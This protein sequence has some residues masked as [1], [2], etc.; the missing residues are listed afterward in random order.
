MLAAANLKPHE[1]EVF[2]GP[3]TGDFGGEK[4]AKSVF[5]FGIPF[6]IMRAMNANGF[7]GVI[8]IARMALSPLAAFSAAPSSLASDPLDAID[9]LVG[10]EGTGTE[11][12]GMMPYTGVPFGSM[13]VVPMTRTNAVGRTSFNALDTHL[14]G[15]CLTRQPAIWMGDT[16]PLRIPVPPA[17]ITR[18]DAHPWQTTVQAGGKTYMWTALGRAAIVRFP[19][20]E[21]P[22][23]GSG[24]STERMD[25]PLGYPLPNFRGYWISERKGNELRIGLSTVSAE[26]AARNLDELPPT[27]EETAAHARAAWSAQIARIDIEAEPDVARIFRTAQY[28]AALY[29]REWSEH[30]VY[31]SAFDDT[32]HTGTAYTAYSLWD[33]YRAEHPLLILTNP[34][35][36]GAMMQSL[37]DIYREGG[38]LPKWPNPGY[39]GIMTGAPA[40]IVLAEAMAKGVTGFDWAGARAAIRKNATVPQKFDTERRWEDRGRF[41]RFP[42]TRGGLTSYLSRGYVACDETAESVSRTLD[43]SFADRNRAYTNLWN[44]QARRFLPRRK[45]G[46]FDPSAKHAYTE[47]SPDTALWCVPHDVPG[48]IALLGGPAAFERELDRY[49]GE[50]FFTP[51]GTGTS[52]HGNEPTHH[53]AYLY[54]YVGNFRKTQRTVRRILSQCYSSGR[55]GFDGNEDCGAMS[56]WYIFSALGFYPVDPVGGTYRL[57]SPAVKSAALKLGTGASQTTLNIRVRN[58]APDRVYVKRATLNGKELADGVLRHADLMRGGELVFEMED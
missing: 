10:T 49:F 54:G 57:G 47:C 24:S 56:A 5:H 26:F 19:P 31:H 25:A 4:R 52:H 20:G 12:G 15:I 53:V 30:G 51:N 22:T 33:T 3:K 23:P 18:I 39:T 7:L 27:F 50:I 17:R 1:G 32:V 13:Q 46:S 36:T 42:E 37:V 21:A 45:D 9:P 2:W 14:L 34:E 29:P 6:D 41:G 38:W 8:L 40:E 35:R 55:R 16:A 58:Y 48:L 44:A 11:Y 43:F 28:H